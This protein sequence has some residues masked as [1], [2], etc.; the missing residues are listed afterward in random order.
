MVI[1]TQF[2]IMKLYLLRKLFA[3]SKFFLFVGC[4]QAL[5]AT[6]ALA[7]SGYAQILE[8][9]YVSSNWEE[10]KLEEAFADIQQQTDFF[11]TYNL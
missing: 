3:K 5:F 6:V 11:F 2:N 9:T 1:K 4:V 7:T 8:D 10:L